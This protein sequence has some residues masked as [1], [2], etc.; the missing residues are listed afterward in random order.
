MTKLKKA[1]PEKKASKESPFKMYWSKTNYIL[2]ITGF[3]VLILGYFLLGRDPWD[4]FISLSVAPMV[5]L[6]AYV[7]I[8]PLAILFINKKKD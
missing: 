4:G 8:F 3:I 7:I 5:L 2:F 6:V 1:I